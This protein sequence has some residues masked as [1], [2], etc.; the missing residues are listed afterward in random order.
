[1]ET[2]LLDYRKLYMAIIKQ[3]LDDAK[4]PEYAEEVR[5][6][7]KSEYYRSIRLFL[8]GSND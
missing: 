1:M 2:N 4:K 8:K 6:F 7:F 5:K 3:A